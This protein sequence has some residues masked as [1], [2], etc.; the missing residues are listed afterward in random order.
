MI[1]V[2]QGIPPGGG[3]FAVPTALRAF[4]IGSAGRSGPVIV[5]AF[6]GRAAHCAARGSFGPAPPLP[7]RRW[8]R[9]CDQPPAQPGRVSSQRGPRVCRLVLPAP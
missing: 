4:G 3:P 1:H 7:G 8:V 9:L 6:G 5:D 2:R